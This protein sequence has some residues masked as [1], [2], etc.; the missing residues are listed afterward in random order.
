[1]YRVV[2]WAVW[3]RMDLYFADLKQLLCNRRLEMEAAVQ[4][5][6]HVISWVDRISAVKLES[7]NPKLKNKLQLLEHL[8]DAL[9]SLSSSRGNLSGFPANTAQRL[10]QQ[11][12]D[13]AQYN[14]KVFWTPEA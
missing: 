9:D 8:Q 2:C 6:Q 4:A 7:V 11:V 3:N 10:Q 12:L 13:F 1:M 5:L 14:A